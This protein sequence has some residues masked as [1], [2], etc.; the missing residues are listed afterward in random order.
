MPAPTPLEQLAEVAAPHRYITLGIPS[1]Q[2]S[3]PRRFILTP[4]AIGMLSASGIEVR[5][6]SGAGQTI[7]YDDARYAASGA[8]I[9]DRRTVLGSDIVL[10][11]PA[12]PLADARMMRRGAMLLT[13]LNSDTADPRTIGELISRS[14]IALALDLVRDTSGN[15][16]FADILSEVDA[17]AAITLAAAALADPTSGK[18]ILLGGIPGIVPCEVTV[19][20]AGIPGRAA[21]RAAIGTGATVRIFDNDIY[22]LRE[23]AASLPA[24]A[25]ASIL[26][27]RVLTSALRTADI[28]VAT[29]PADISSDMVG[30]M[31]LGTIVYDLNPP[32]RRAFP[33]VPTIDLATDPDRAHPLTDSTGNPTRTCF[34][35]PGATVSRTCA[36]GVSNAFVAMMRDI[37]TCDGPGNAIRLNPGMQGA[38][39]TFMGRLTN[40]SLARRSSLRYTDIHI[41]VHLS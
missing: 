18:G 35:N 7:H 25:I 41:L 27:P 1:P 40:A 30:A 39:L 11:L 29:V 23:T 34:L 12:L 6:E 3:G 37:L 36:M 2:G 4:E 10:H 22:A 14:V 32:R 38:V 28:V 8:R 17:L 21:A 9:C 24:H 15:R 31:K 33:T 26:N 16:P 5:L 19:I 13:L 20:G